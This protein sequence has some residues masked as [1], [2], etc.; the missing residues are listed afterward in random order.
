[1]KTETIP[2]LPLQNFA[3]SCMLL[4]SHWHVGLTCVTNMW[5]LVMSPPCAKA[6]SGGAPLRFG[7]KMVLRCLIP[8]RWDQIQRTEPVY[9]ELDVHVIFSQVTNLEEHSVSE[10]E[11][12][13]L[14]SQC[15]FLFWSL[16]K[17]FF[18]NGPLGKGFP[19]M[20]PSTGRHPSWN[21][22]W[23]VGHQGQWCP[24]LSRWR[25]SCHVGLEECHPR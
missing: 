1:M 10:E 9:E 12:A 18:T 25:G 13:G 8:D 21:P 17:T 19:Y 3:I 15:N 4:M 14:G 16:W 24:S 11:A 6:L 7:S 23:I 5:T 20:D 22:K 2:Y